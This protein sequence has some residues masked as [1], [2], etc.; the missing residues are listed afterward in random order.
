MLGKISRS[1]RASVVLPLEEQPLRPIT[2]LLPSLI[3]KDLSDTR[4][5]ITVSQGTLT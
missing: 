3:V 5:L 4:I 1:K 2:T